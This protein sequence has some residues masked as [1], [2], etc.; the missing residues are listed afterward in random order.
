MENKIFKV[1]DRVFDVFF[2][3]GTVDEVGDNETEYSVRVEWDNED[4]SS[5]SYTYDGRYTLGLKR[6][7]RLS[8][9]E[10]DLVNGGFSQERDLNVMDV[11]Y[12]KTAE[13]A[14]IKVGYYAGMTNIGIPN[15]K[16]HTVYLSANKDEM[17][18]G[19]AATTVVTFVT[20]IN[21]LS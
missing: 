12:Y 19:D 3:W 7:P 5:D 17:G 14:D 2:G 9:T 20:T 11:V 10:Y 6:V 1:G 16:Y 18:R 21:P 4:E 15:K 8:F 13:S